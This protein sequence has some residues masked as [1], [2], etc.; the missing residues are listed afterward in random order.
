M[1]FLHWLAGMSAFSTPITAESMKME[2]PI[3]SNV[4]GVLEDFEVKQG[5]QIEAGTVLAWIRK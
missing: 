2:T 5:Q 3:N 4:N 1:K